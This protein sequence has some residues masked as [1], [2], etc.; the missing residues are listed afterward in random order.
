MVEVNVKDA[1]SQFSAL[2]DRVEKGEE[3]I[4][5][6]RGKR[7]AV[8]RAY[9]DTSVLVAYYRPEP[10]SEA[11]EKMILR[12]RELSRENANR[13][14]TQFQ[15]HLDRFL[16]K[17]IPVE[18]NHYSAALDWLAQFAI[19]LRALDP[20]HPAVAGATTWKS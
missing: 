3:I 12:E 1:R 13:V 16:F 20:L 2:L 8:L 15:S 11:A 7:R 9:V 14:L 4:I 18:L 19:P 5:K 17:R 6:R 10:L